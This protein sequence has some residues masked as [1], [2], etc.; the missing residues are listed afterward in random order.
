[1]SPFLSGALGAFAALFTFA[2][3]R[4]GFRVRTRH[5]HGRTVPLRFLFRRL[6]TRP[7]QERVISAEAESLASELHALRA[8]MGRVRDEVADLLASPTTDAA[9]VQA[10]IDAQ[11]AKV[12]GLRARLAETFA[13]IHGAL[14][15]EQRVTL[16]A[17]VR[18]GPHRHR[19]A[20]AHG[21]C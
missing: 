2:L 12:T 3:L 7:E 9:A 6:G 10:A 19:C 16:A 20:H 17:L 5:L 4:R 15:P 1:M 11:L 8:D 21:R 14:D 18:S 13:R